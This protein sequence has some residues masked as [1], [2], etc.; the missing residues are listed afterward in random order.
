MDYEHAVVVDNETQKTGTFLKDMRSR[1]RADE[2]RQQAAIDLASCF[3]PLSCSAWGSLSTAHSNEGGSRSSRS[4]F[5]QKHPPH[6]GRS[7]QTQ[8]NL[9]PASG[10]FVKKTSE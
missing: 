9:H 2:E 7:Q 5:L 3:V 1:Y 10:I 6:R 8:P 4:L